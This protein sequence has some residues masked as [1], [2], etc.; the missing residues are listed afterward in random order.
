MSESA[1][2]LVEDVPNEPYGSEW[3][4]R[5]SP[6]VREEVARRRRLW[7]L[8]LRAL[9]L[10]LANIAHTTEWSEETVA[11]DVKEAL[12][13]AARNDVKEIE[14]TR[15]LMEYRYNINLER[16]NRLYS[17]ENGKDVPDVALLATLVDKINSTNRLIGTLYGVEKNVIDVNVKTDVVVFGRSAPLL[18]EEET[19]EAKAV[20]WVEAELVEGDEDGFSSE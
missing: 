10:G 1:A 11:K 4:R 9:G 5:G 14:R 6:R 3:R 8:R 16:L 18:S 17:E 12:D 7:H 2:V 20:D 19:G 15:S 13:V